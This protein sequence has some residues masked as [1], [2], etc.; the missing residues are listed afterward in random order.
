MITGFYTGILG[1]M[2]IVLIFAVV[3]RRIKYKVGLGDGGIP[4]LSRAIRVHGNFVETVP[5]LLIIMYLLETNAAS[6][7]L[8]HIFGITIVVARLLHARGI[9]SSPLRSFGRTGGVALCQLLMLVGSL[10]LIAKFI[11]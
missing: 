1:I 8:L 6:P 9:Y 5:F 7:V 11:W 10:M 3:H 4:D 2:L